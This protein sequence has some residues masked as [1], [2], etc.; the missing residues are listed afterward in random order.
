VAQSNNLDAQITHDG[1]PDVVVRG[2][3][4]R[5]YGQWRPSAAQAWQRI[6]DFRPIVVLAG[7]IPD[8]V[9]DVLASLGARP[10]GIAAVEEASSL[11]AT[12]GALVIDAGST[13]TGRWGQPVAA[14][15]TRS[16]APPILFVATLV[17]RSPVRCNEARRFVAEA[18]PSVIRG[19][20]AELAALVG[21]EAPHG[22]G[23]AVAASV[24]QV[25]AH[26]TSA[27]V[28]AWTE[29]EVATADAR[30]MRSAAQSGTPAQVR[31]A[32]HAL[33][34][35]IAATLA[36]GAEPHAGV[37]AAVSLTDAAIRTS[38]DRALG[39]GA[40]AIGLLDVLAG[41]GDVHASGVDTD[42]GETRTDEPSP[43]HTSP[44]GHAIA[45]SS[46]RLFPQAVS[47]VPLGPPTLRHASPSATVSPISPPTRHAA[48][49]GAPPSRYDP[50]TAI[51]E[52]ANRF[53]GGRVVPGSVPAHLLRHEPETFARDDAVRWS[54]VVAV[55]V[56]T[57]EG[58]SAPTH[59]PADE[60]RTPS[61]EALS[62]AHA[63]HAA[64]DAGA[65]AILVDVKGMT[66]ASALVAVRHAVS[67]ASARSVAVA[68]V[69][70]VDVAVA[71]GADGVWL[72]GPDASLPVDAAVKVASSR[73]VVIAPVATFEDAQ[74][75]V[76]AGAGALWVRP[77]GEA[78]ATA[79]AQRPGLSSRPT[80]SA[81]ACA[82]QANLSDEPNH[83]APLDLGALA[84]STGVAVACLVC[85][86]SP[87][88]T[89]ADRDE[90]HAPRSTFASPPD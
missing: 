67:V 41:V 70:R 9:T 23:H 77:L 27:I 47:G 72:T 49:G 86:E 3:V 22:T 89:P 7:V 88:E 39:P 19:T 36:C 33:D 57:A 35:T 21:L 8:G 6:R 87:D 66:D 76:A 52:V 51:D 48:E 18:R 84:A 62:T 16:G 32:S 30:T 13:V 79:L 20:V 85:P 17:D 64:V 59:V 25:V 12:C 73:L 69:G 10:V 58:R 11:L 80:L 60:E 45:D 81:Y 75:A 71:S 5:E 44:T 54:R 63:I 55:E 61:A 37:R 29:G 78:Q 14:A 43:T 68:V 34:A 46:S 26:Q 83:P 50:W 15:R 82:G 4:A 90:D 24:A 42:D 53:E 40:F 1:P 56:R 38:A 31:L 28:V 65:T 2:D 74:A